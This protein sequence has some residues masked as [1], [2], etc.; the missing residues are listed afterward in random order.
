MD[1]Q[2]SL[3]HLLKDCPFPIS[4]LGTLVRY[5]LTMYVRVVYSVLV[6]C[7]S[8]FMPG[9]H[10]LDYY[11]FIIINFEYYLYYIYA[12]HIPTTCVYY[13]FEYCAVYK[14]FQR[15]I[16]KLLMA[17]YFWPMNHFLNIFYNCDSAGLLSYLFIGLPCGTQKSLGQGSKTSH[18]CN[19]NHSNDNAR[20]LT[21]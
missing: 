9:P 1:I 6:V 11:S 7:L 18:S 5:N 14:N 19:Q 3:H 13:F 20:S 17:V 2:F 15:K 8:V 12:S 4:G 21:Y 16:L 10:F